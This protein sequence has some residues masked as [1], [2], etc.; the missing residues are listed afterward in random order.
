MSNR[1]PAAHNP[2]Q[3]RLLG[4]GV[5]VDVVDVEAREHPVLATASTQLTE[6]FAGS[7]TTF[8]LPLDPVGT[9]FQRQAWAVLE[10]IPYGRTI[11]Y[12]EQAEMLGDRKKARA[13][14]AANGANPIP[15]LVPCHRVVSSTGQLTG[16]AGGLRTKAWLLEHERAR[17]GNS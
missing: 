14:G 16:F 17:S 12:G 13:V 8:E 9:A 7:R 6:Y 5:V 1:L 10:R 15:I 11:S 3:E 4:A 2:V